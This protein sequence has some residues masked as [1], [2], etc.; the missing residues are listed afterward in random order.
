MP[1]T[2]NSVTYLTFCI[3]ILLEFHFRKPTGNECQ[4]TIK[5]CSTHTNI[6]CR[7]PPRWRL[8]WRRYGDSISCSITLTTLATRNPPQRR[9]PSAIGK[10][11]IDNT[12]TQ[13]SSSWTQTVLRDKSALIGW[14]YHRSSSKGFCVHHIIMRGS[15][16]YTELCAKGRSLCSYIFKRVFRAH[17]IPLHCNEI[18]ISKSKCYIWFKWMY[19]SFKGLVKLTYT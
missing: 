16:N 15:T 13:P 10:W 3:D 8:F 11:K 5:L 7:Q 2:A 19:I 6:P 1:Q 9:W 4:N 17:E 12:Y 14:F 18:H